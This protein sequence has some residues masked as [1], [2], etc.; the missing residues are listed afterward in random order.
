MSLTRWF[1]PHFMQI[2]CYISHSNLLNCTALK[3]L[4]WLSPGF[5]PELVPHCHCIIVQSN[6]EILPLPVNYLSFTS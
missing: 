2:T 1:L 4:E 5:T 6:T 3:L